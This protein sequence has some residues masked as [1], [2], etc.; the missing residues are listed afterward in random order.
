MTDIDHKALADAI[1]ADREASIPGTVGPWVQKGWSITAEAASNPEVGNLGG[2]ICA[3]CAG[4][5][6][7]Y[8]ADANARR[9]ARTPDLE[10]AYLQLAD[11]RRKKDVQIAAMNRSN[12]S[13][14]DRVKELEGVNVSLLKDALDRYMPEPPK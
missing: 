13:L 9:I 10:S 2:M 4:F 6:N 5:E 3:V 11:E 1:R 12:E 14:L 8:E 7:A